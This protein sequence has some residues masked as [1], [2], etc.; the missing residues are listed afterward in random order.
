MSTIIQRSVSER[1]R[2]KCPRLR[3]E[4]HAMIECPHRTRRIRECRHTESKLR[5]Q[6]RLEYVQSTP[7]VATI[8]NNKFASANPRGG[9]GGGG[10]GGAGGGAAGSANGPGTASSVT[11]SSSDVVGGSAANVSKMYSAVSDGELL[12]LAILPIFQKLLTERHKSSSRAGY[13]ASVASC[14]NI[15]IKCDIVEYL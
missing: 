5:Q 1:S 15:S 6:A 12:D 14:P 11:G 13:G 3:S 7:N 10:G 9:G 2:E 4:G 8:H